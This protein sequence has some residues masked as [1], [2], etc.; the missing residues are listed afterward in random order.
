MCTKP[1]IFL[2]LFCL[3][4]FSFSSETY[5]QDSKIFSK[6]SLVHEVKSQYGEEKLASMLYLCE[7]FSRED[8]KLTLQFIDET[9]ALSE[10]LDKPLITSDLYR[11]KGISNSALGYT[12][13]AF[14]N[15]KEALFRAKKLND[16]LLISKGLHS[17]GSHYNRT[18]NY[19]EAEI[20]YT[21]A[22]SL[23]KVVGNQKMIFLTQLNL[24]TL[25][26]KRG[27]HKK[28]IVIFGELL[29]KCPSEDIDCNGVLLNKAICTYMLG[30]PSEALDMLFEAKNI[31]EANNQILRAQYGTHHIAYILE[32][33]ELFEESLKYY[34][35]VL[36]YFNEQGE[37]VQQAAVNG[38]VGSLL[39]KLNRYE[40]AEEHLLKALRL[41]KENGFQDYG[42]TLVELGNLALYRKDS[43]AA[44]KY[45]RKA[46][47]L[48]KKVKD[49]RGI[50]LL[51][52]GKADLSIYKSDYEQAEVNTQKAL[53]VGKR[54]KLVQ[55]Q[56][57]SYKKLGHVF[58]E[59]DKFEDALKARDSMRI[60]NLGVADKSTALDINQKLV[61]RKLTENEEMISKLEEIVEEEAVAQKTMI[62]IISSIFLGVLGGILYFNR[63]KLWK[64]RFGTK[65]ATMNA[66][67]AEALT[68]S[69]EKI[70]GSAR[71]YLN[72]DLTLI[73]LAEH[74]PSSQKKLS[75][76]LNTYL[77]T[78][79]YDYINKYRVA[80]FK[81]LLEDSNYRE[82]STLG[83]ANEC[84]FKSK[85]SF[86]RAFKK[87]TGLSPGEYKKQV[88]N[89]MV[90]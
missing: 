83:I 32:S 75:V 44:A 24:G 17:L 10:K 88:L 28:A 65:T 64:S 47:P 72:E 12:E 35:D 79:F 4:Y 33:V 16:T 78:N 38:T 57:D 39:M 63:R 26:I 55:I 27:L 62:A 52:L 61:R 90:S 1:I 49:K 37:L 81:I 56:I 73:Q 30:K 9:I 20:N 60:I 66:E 36:N 11:Q 15:Y 6:D 67:E 87:E 3:C 40:E 7:K 82:Y 2:F 54:L 22:K 50:A 70:M 51:F 69:L 77:N 80:A 43:S 68:E 34:S 46:E 42:R 76:L 14:L 13:R 8:P 48:L 85:S 45:F 25:Y 29:E 74:L 84:G 21:K 5:G 31:D 86:Y 18:G 71:P 41:Q 59:Q 23:A 19:V 53:F 58:E 89:K